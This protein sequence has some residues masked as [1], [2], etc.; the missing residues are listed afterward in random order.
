[1]TNFSGRL[2]YCC[3]LLWL[4]LLASMSAAAADAAMWSALKA[5]QTVVF[6]RHAQTEPGIGDPEGFS[7]AD[8]ATQ[9]N[10][11]AQGRADAQRIGQAIRERQIVISAVLSS[12]WC[13]CLDTARIAFGKVTPAVML[14]SMFND[15]V[16]PAS[17]KVTEL[18]TFIAGWKAPGNL[19]LVTHAQNIDHLTG[20]S[21]RSGEFVVTRFENGRYHVLGRFSPAAS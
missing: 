2:R 18:Q 19:V 13:R 5:G 9:R 20:V 10:L 15:P 16:K 14:D 7:V 1:M 4:L 12:R 21:P 3:M 8:C 17:E 6:V 11:S